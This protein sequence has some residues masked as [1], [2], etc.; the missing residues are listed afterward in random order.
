MNDQKRETVGKISAELLTK[1]PDSRDP[2]ELEREMHKDYENHIFES[3]KD[4]LKNYVGDFF[5]EVT[6]KKEPLMPNVIRNYFSARRSC[7][8][9]NYDQTIYKYHRNDD[10]IE[11]LWVVPSKDTCELLYNNML[12]VDPEER[13]LLSFVLS[14]YDGTL[15]DLAKKLNKEFEV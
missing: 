8:S 14:F 4:G 15:L 11:F 13:Q 12:E 7:A 1:A 10:K 5:I 3:I 2:I 6:T 9:P